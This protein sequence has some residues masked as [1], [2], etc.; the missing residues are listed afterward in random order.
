VPNIARVFVCDCAPGEKL[1]IEIILR[2]T[3]T[4]AIESILTAYILGF[5]NGKKYLPLLFSVD[6]VLNGLLSPISLSSSDI[7]FKDQIIQSAIREQNTSEMIL[8]VT[9]VS[10]GTIKFHAST[11]STEEFTVEP[12]K[13]YLEKEAT[14]NFK[15][16]F[17]SQKAGCFESML[18]LSINDQ[19]IV[20]IIP[21]KLKGCAF[22]PSILFDPPEIF[23]PILPRNLTTSATFFIINIGCQMTDI[24]P[25][26]PDEIIKQGGNI[27][28]IFPEGSILKKYGE[29]LP[30]I[31]RYTQNLPI[32]NEKF[33][34]ISFTIRLPFEDTE[35]NQFYL[36]IYG[37]SDNSLLTLLPYFS[38]ERG[39]SKE[40]NN[41][42]IH[43][44][45]S[46][47]P[48]EFKTPS[49]FILKNSDDAA[50]VDLFWTKTIYSIHVWFHDYMGTSAVKRSLT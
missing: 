4:S 17:K 16:V 9:N 21:I 5:N 23:L 45:I 3:D 44:F 33:T 36:K 26:I 37:T 41:P 32:E 29:R 31:I 10:N 1:N 38:S 47:L 19:N 35:K 49:G 8:Q 14:Q 40:I 20:S 28:L 46:N 34:P 15:V 25:P 24:T 12:I 22:N 39:H 48:L 18:N 6:I 13:G 11:K 2:P 7:T 30:C 50:R 27:E 42:F 43:K